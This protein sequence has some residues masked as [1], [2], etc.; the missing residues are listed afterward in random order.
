MRTSIGPDTMEKTRR[1]S[2]RIR[3]Y[4]QIRHGVDADEHRGRTSI[5][6]F[7]AACQNARKTLKATQMNIGV[8][9]CPGR[10]K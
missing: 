6:V 9:H 4:A 10:A 3:S 1:G 5:V 8:R 2:N 7:T